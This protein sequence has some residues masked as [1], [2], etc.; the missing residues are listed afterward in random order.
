MTRLC[1]IAASGSFFPISSRSYFCRVLHRL[2]LN[3]LSA[4]EP[5]PVRRYW[6][7]PGELIR[8]GASQDVMPDERKTSA[9]AFVEAAVAPLC[10]AGHPGRARNDRQLLLLQSNAFRAT[11]KVFTRP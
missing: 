8:S 9:G 3:K 1:P 10:Q 7:H 4:L 5:E 6:E 11:C 2:G